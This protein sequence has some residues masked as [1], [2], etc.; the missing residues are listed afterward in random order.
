MLYKCIT[1]LH[2]F[3]YSF[4]PISAIY[5]FQQETFLIL[6]SLLY[7]KEIESGS[8]LIYFEQFN[9]IYVQCDNVWFWSTD[10]CTNIEVQ[11]LII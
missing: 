9:K 3:V 10:Y 6:L 2:Y 8:C 5:L 11:E 4:T 7:L 1:Q